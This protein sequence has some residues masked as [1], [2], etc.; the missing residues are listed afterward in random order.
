MSTPTPSNP[1]HSSKTPKAH[2][3]PTPNT[4]SHLGAFSSPATRNA[5]SPAAH[6]NTISGKSPMTLTHASAPTSG[7]HNHLTGSSTGGASDTKRGGLLG[8]SPAGVGINFDSPSGGMGL[9]L[10]NTGGVDMSVSFSQMGGLSMGLSM[11]GLGMGMVGGSSLGIG[12]RTDDERRRILESIVTLIGSR[13]GKVCEEGIRRAAK[14]VGLDTSVDEGKNN[15]KTIT[16]AGTSSLM[17]DVHIRSDVVEKVNVECEAAPEAWKTSADVLLRDLTSQPGQS[18]LTLTLEK[19]SRN[20]EVLARFEKL[21]APSFNC[22][23]AIS[24]V[25]NS[26]QKL[27][28]HEK[29]IATASLDSKSP[30]LEEKAER[31]VMCKKSG[32]PR[33]NAGDRVGLSL[34]YWTDRRHVLHGD[35]VTSSAPNTPIVDHME[36]DEPVDI[37]HHLGPDRIHSIQIECESLPVGMYPAM[38]ISDSWLSDMIEKADD[39]LENIGE[40]L[41]GSKIDW[42]DPPP[43]YVQE[44]TENISSMGNEKPPGVRFMARFSPPLIVPLRVAVALTQDVNA[45]LAQDQYRAVAWDS[46]ALHPGSEGEIC[47]ALTGLNQIHSERLILVKDSEEIQRKHKN[48]LH[49]PNDG[50]GI[51][52]EQVP[53]EHPRQLVQMLPI[54]RR[55]AMLN[56]MLQTSFSPRSDSPIEKPTSANATR[57]LPDMK[58]DVLVDSLEPHT[59]LTV[60]FPGPLHAYSTRDLKEGQYKHDDGDDNV[61]MGPALPKDPKLPLSVSFEIGNNAE[62]T[63]L[64]QNVDSRTNTVPGESSNETPEGA[65]EFE[66]RAQDTKRS[67]QLRRR[68]ARALDVSVD[69]GVWAEWLCT[70]HFKICQEN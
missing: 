10:S 14:K 25:Y 39:G 59:C 29:N 21:S 47:T 28:V 54:L 50:Y 57:V 32:R 36:T 46:L 5:A 48:A 8:S 49:V 7:S 65:L 35:T 43:T 51:V 34:E 4:I 6:R 23:A 30:Q 22:F 52:L 19:F 37:A 61:V 16:I 13:S 64:A 60:V 63:I 69:I 53:F 41:H 9:N 58:V 26:L 18:K 12:S 62:I 17:V 55:Y 70:E 27:F 20:L 2:N 40:A 42:L 45:P 56:S 24:A 15:Q 33:M 66:S 68:L 11:S 67:V 3:A 38:R 31:H 1:A 44:D